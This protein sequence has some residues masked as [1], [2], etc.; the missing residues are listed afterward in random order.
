MR[1]EYEFLGRW[2]TGRVKDDAT[3]VS[4]V[5]VGNKRVHNK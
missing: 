2:K 4:V 3:V 5:V 1:C